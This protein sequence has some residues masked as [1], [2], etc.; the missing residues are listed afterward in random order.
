MDHPA[1]LGC[2]LRQV[3][4]R[5]DD[6]WLYVSGSYSHDGVVWR[7]CAGK[8]HGAAFRRTAD[9]FHPTEAAALVAALEAAPKVQP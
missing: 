8:H 7:V 9:Q 1:T 6:E 4:E 5:W 2:L 3:R